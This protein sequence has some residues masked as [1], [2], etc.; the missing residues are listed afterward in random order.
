MQINIQAKGT[1]LTAALREYAEK[2]LQKIE[3][4]FHNIQKID[5]DLEVN[6]IKEEAERQIAKVTVWASGKTIHAT[7]ATSDMYSSIDLI[8]D[9]LDQQIKK[10]KEKL[11]DEKRRD[12]AKNKQILHETLLSNSPVNEEETTER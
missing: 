10:F 5:I 6:K 12:S 4:F 1:E 11:I 8:I 3:H 2:K 9:K 7:E